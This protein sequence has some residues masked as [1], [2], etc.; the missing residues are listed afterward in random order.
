[1]INRMWWQFFGRGIVDPVDDMHQG[2]QPS[3]PELLEELSQRFAESGFNL[4]LLCRSIL[5]SRTYQ[6]TSRRGEQA[7]AETQYFA[8]MPIKVLTA[9]QLYDSLVQILGPPSKTPGIDARLGAR[10]EFRQFFAGDGD[11]DPTRYDCRSAALDGGGG[12]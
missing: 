5:L 2:N 3:H 9:E 7:D 10:N 8:R 6:Q 4:K 1:M 11:P 12:G